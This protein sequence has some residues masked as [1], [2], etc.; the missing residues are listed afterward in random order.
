MY[1]ESLCVGNMVISALRFRRCLSCAVVFV[2]A[3]P[4][5]STSGLMALQRPL[6]EQP[7]IRNNVLVSVEAS[8]LC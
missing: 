4:S 1:K 8:V 3:T 5:D 2:G 6:S 7:L